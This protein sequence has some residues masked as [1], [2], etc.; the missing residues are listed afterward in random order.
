MP[1]N[2]NVPARYFINLSPT[3]TACCVCEA[4]FTGVWRKQDAKN[5]CGD[6]K[7][8]TLISEFMDRN[9][10]SL[11]T[12]KDNRAGYHKFPK[13]DGEGLRFPSGDGHWYRG[14]DEKLKRQ[15]EYNKSLQAAER[16]EYNELKAAV[17]Q[18]L[19]ADGKERPAWPHKTSPLQRLSF[20]FWHG[21]W[22]QVKDAA[23]ALAYDSHVQKMIDGYRARILDLDDLIASLE[24]DEFMD[25]L[26]EGGEHDD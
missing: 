22:S 10:S 4:V 25:E 21:N 12:Y 23:I 7:P 17:N 8:L 14:S 24:I 18:L 1:K 20:A 13:R 11:R 3:E 26:N 6:K 2:Y 16:K 19:T 5:C 9:F 15:A